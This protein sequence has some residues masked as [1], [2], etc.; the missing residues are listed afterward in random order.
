VPGGIS[1]IQGHGG[2]NFYADARGCIVVRPDEA[3]GL[4]AAGCSE[5]AKL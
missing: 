1:T 5:F 3:A 4:I 2:A